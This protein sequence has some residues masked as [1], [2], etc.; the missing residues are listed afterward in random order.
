MKRATAGP[1]RRI[2]PPNEIGR[3]MAKAEV[4]G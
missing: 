3:L 1:S 2:A 4:D